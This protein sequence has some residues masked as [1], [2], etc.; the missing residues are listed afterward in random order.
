L[1]VNGADDETTTCALSRGCCEVNR[2]AVKAVC[3]GL[4][5]LKKYDFSNIVKKNCPL[6]FKENS[7]HFYYYFNCWFTLPDSGIDWK[8]PIGHRTC[9]KNI[10]AI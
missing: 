2:A 7:I 9:S 5:H 1:F 6:R 10:C 4:Y 3:G 8:T